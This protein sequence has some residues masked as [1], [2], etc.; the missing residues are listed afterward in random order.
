MIPIQ[1]KGHARPL[2]QI[3]FNSEG[4]IF[5][6]VG[7]DR[8]A[9]VWFTK[10]GERLGTLPHGG[11]VMTVDI[12]RET[13][14]AVTGTSDQKVCFWNLKTGELI[15]ELQF[16]AT[17]RYVQ[18]H[19][20]GKQ[21]KLLAVQDQHMGQ[22]ST[23]RVFDI[24]LSDFSAPKVD[25]SLLIEYP[26]APFVK[27]AWTYDGDRIIAVHNEGSVSRINALTGEFE[28]IKPVHTKN[29]VDVQMSPD[30]TY[31][32]TASRDSTACIMEV[33]GDFETGRKV[34]RGD[35]P[36]NTAA[37][38]PIKDIVIAGGGID[39]R[40]VTTSSGSKFEAHFFHKIFADDLG[41]VE[42]HFGPINTIAIH[43]FGLS[44][45]SGSED[46]YMRIHNFDKSYFE[47]EYPKVSA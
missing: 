19:P 37:I 28:L 21:T 20:L 23:I 15:Y 42:G 47:F 33:D 39:A 26:Q 3:K 5:V 18:I 17:Q 35:V 16:K 43:P 2:T 31:F 12:D 1:L 9:N 8:I 27:A 45:I 44:Y 24:D 34:F 29:I 40:E 46:G 30:R 22:T 11:S 7:R 10:T 25:E 36:L 32:V 13:R 4:D 6:S 38:S 41:R 14:Y